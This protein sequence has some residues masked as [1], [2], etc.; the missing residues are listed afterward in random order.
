MVLCGQ[1][2]EGLDSLNEGLKPEERGNGD[3]RWKLSAKKEIF[4]L[5][6]I[7]I[8]TYFSAART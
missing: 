3:R 2:K 1:V 6:G 7:V 5:A 4:C 8:A